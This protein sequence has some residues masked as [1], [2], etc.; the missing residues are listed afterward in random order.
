MI[1]RLKMVNEDL[2]RNDSAHN[3]EIKEMQFEIDN[4]KAKY[5]NFQQ[6]F[7]AVDG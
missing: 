6:F 2:K 5:Q 7:K 4:W 3:K 1:K